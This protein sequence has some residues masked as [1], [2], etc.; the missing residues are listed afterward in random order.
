MIEGRRKEGRKEGKE[1]YPSS[2]S[3]PE[4]NDIGYSSKIQHG[5]FTPKDAARHAMEETTGYNRDTRSA[6]KLHLH[7]RAARPGIIIP[8]SPNPPSG[9]HRGYESTPLTSKYIVDIMVSGLGREGRR[10]LWFLGRVY[11]M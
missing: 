10:G 4:S 7:F 2:D 9:R 11:V 3:R 5:T 1:E 8:T 6:H